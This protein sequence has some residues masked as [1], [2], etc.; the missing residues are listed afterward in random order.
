MIRGTTPEHIIKPPVAASLIKSVRFTY[1][2][3]GNTV[4][5]KTEAD[6]TITDESISVRLTQ[7]D[8]LRFE[9]NKSVSVQ[10]R[11]LTTGGEV[12]ASDIKSLTVK[13]TLNDEVLE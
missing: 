8:T 11:I 4:V 10:I 2:Q 13:K 6:C 5:E 7:D 12:M 1:E 3:D 9:E